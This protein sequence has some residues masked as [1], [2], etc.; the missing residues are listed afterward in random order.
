LKQFDI[1]E[2]T[3][4]VGTLFV[5]SPKSNPPKWATFFDEFVDPTELGRVA[6]TAGA[7]LVKTH[8]RMFALTFGQGRFLL[9]DDSWEERFGLRVALNSVGEN[10]LRSVDKVTFDAIAAHTR[11]QSSRTASAFEFGLDVEQDLVRAVTGI[12][13]DEALGR[14]ITGMDA[15]HASVRVELKTLRGL[16]R[17]YLDQY[18]DLSYKKKFPWVDHI[19][20]VT[21]QTMIAE[22]D[23]E[24]CAK[25]NGVRDRCWLAIPEI[26][27]WTR[28]SGFRFS[29]S[30]KVPQ[31][32]DVRLDDF[33]ES[34]GKNKTVTPDRLSSRHVYGVDDDGNQVYSWTV[35]KALYCE[36][37]KNGSMYVLSAGRWYRIDRDFVSTV[38][39]YFAAVPRAA[40]DLPEFHHGSEAEY[41]ADV[42]AT[43]KERYVLLDQRTI[44]IGGRYGKI[45]LCDLFTSTKDFV[46]VK[47]YGASGVLSHLFAQGAIS[48]EAFRYEADFRAKAIDLLPMAF[49][50]K[51]E[52]PAPGDFNIVFAI[53]SEKAGGITVPFFS[54][55][56]LRQTIKRLEAFGYKA[57]I[58]KI[59]VEEAFAKTKK[60]DSH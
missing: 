21:N 59:T 26:I 33:I 20:E 28:V 23:V 8:G 41:C 42:A 29:F 36:I 6:S 50:W 27:D 17:R 52:P 46:H 18:E 3:G 16:L 40:L 14:R 19:A 2:G 9:K 60:Y 34:L 58:Q 25:I 39:K 32:P 4:K 53:I 30:A 45:E 56:N 13:S 15:L 31:V 22:L 35:R 10:S 37:Q 12:P 43:Q 51:D 55:V 48:A 1:G 47:R 24:A 54:R 49:R 44:N 11:T 5:R 38:D 7:F 57:A